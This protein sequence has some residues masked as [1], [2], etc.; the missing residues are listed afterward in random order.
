MC[1][2]HAHGR[3]SGHIGTSGPYSQQFLVEVSAV[4]MGWLS[5]HI[6]EVYPVFIVN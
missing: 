5:E 4:F 3:L 1:S 6:R 2:G